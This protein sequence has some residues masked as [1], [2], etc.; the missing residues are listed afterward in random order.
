VDGG[1]LWVEGS[2]G[3]PVQAWVHASNRLQ[4]RT[5]GAPFL[6]S[7]SLRKAFPSQ[8]ESIESNDVGLNP[9]SQIAATV[10]SRL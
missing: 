9:G 6:A 1:L 2:M 4:G 10:P 5:Q 7:E 3:G 8:A